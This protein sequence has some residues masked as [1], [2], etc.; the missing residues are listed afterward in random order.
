MLSRGRWVVLVAA[1]VAAA[2][3]ARLGLWQLDRAAQK[4]ERQARI[5]A[6][7]R[8]PVLA[9]AELPGPGRSDPELEFRRAVLE[10][11][12]LA[13]HTVFLDN[14]QMGG[15]PGFVIV[16]PLQL[17]SGDA[18]LVQRGWVPR[19]FQDRTAVPDVPTPEDR[20]V[21]LSVRVA[22]P[23]AKLLELGE[24]GAGR[25][26][27]NLDP[28]GYARE[29]GMPLRTWSAWQLDVARTVG[30]PAAEVADGLR[31][32]WPAPATDVS[33]HH[34]YAFQWFALSALIIGLYV[35]F[36]LIQPRRRA[37]RAPR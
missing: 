9:P 27:Q 23:P 26:R 19:H 30:E 20:P 24:A 8:A 33:K 17:S 29:I 25:I 31:R 2:L 36:Q 28:E 6:R 10:G 32:D 5:E 3:T 35:W 37:A 16:T 4:T 12:W 7:D 13:R 14:R 22:P 21:R 18:V 11:R 34:G 15:R 1:V